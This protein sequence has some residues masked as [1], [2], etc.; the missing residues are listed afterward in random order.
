[1]RGGAR[2][3]R[4][5]ARPATTLKTGTRKTSLPFSGLLRH[6]RHMSRC[7]Q[8]LAANIRLLCARRPLLLAHV[9]IDVTDIFRAESFDRRHASETPVVWGDAKPDRHEKSDIGMVRGP[10]DHV[11]QRRT[12]L[13]ATRIIPVTPGTVGAE[14]LPT[15]AGIGDEVGTGETQA[16]GSL[17]GIRRLAAQQQQGDG[18]EHGTGQQKSFSA[19]TTGAGSVKQAD[20]DADLVAVRRAALRAGGYLTLSST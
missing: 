20:A 8:Q 17:P 6:L 10:V 15:A 1:M 11:R 16:L 3:W 13:C 5:R 12:L 19:Q 9:G 14:Q 2:R 18:G 7:P 4:Y